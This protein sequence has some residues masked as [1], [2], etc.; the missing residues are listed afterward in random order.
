MKI[1][2]ILKMKILNLKKIK[3]INTL[4]CLVFESLAHK[5]DIHYVYFIL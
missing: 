4:S 1:P 2:F 3:F 5:I